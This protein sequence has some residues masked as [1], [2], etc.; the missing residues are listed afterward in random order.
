MRKSIKLVNNFSSKKELPTNI[1]AN[2]QNIIKKLKRFD[3]KLKTK[4]RISI[5]NNLKD[6]E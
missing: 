6:I 1:S 2:K 4:K 3:L 5:E